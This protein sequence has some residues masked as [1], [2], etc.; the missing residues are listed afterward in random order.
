MPRNGDIYLKTFDA[1]CP[2]EEDTEIAMEVQYLYA[3]ALGAN[4][5][6]SFKPGF[7]KHTFACSMQNRCKLQNELRGRRAIC[8]LYRDEPDFLAPDEIDLDWI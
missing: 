5:G 2:L 8:P 1:Y 3:E 4:V 7:N 6:T